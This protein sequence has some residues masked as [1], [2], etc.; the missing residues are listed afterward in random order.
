MSSFGYENRDG[1]ST[2]LRSIRASIDES[3]TGLEPVNWN[4]VNGLLQQL[5]F[6]PS[7]YKARCSLEDDPLGRLLIGRILSRNPPLATL[8]AALAVFPESLD[9]NASAFFTACRDGTTDLLAH[10]MH[11]TTTKKNEGENQK[12]ENECPYPWILSSHISVEGAQAILEVFPQGV[13]QKSSMFSMYNLVDYFLMSK[14]MIEQ[15]NFDFTLWSKF[16]LILVAAE[17]CESGRE[18][19]EIY[20]V[21][22]ILKR[23]L[24]H[25]GFLENKEWTQHV[26]WLL[27]QLRWSDQWVFEKQT[28]DGKNPIHLVLSHQCT[29]KQEG[30]VAA[31]ELAK[32]L[33]EA[34]PQSAKRWVDG[35]LPLHMAVKNGWPCHD[36]LL[37]LFPEALD[38][39]DMQTELFPFQAAAKYHLTPLSLDIAY[40]LLRANPSCA[41][42]MTEGRRVRAQG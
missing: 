8:D 4:I 12:L 34:H 13:L 39:R 36:L 33:L 2:L 19:G 38:A 15:R 16:K 25:P 40:E 28:S 21:H 17:S 30:L 20:P 1:P 14:D 18:H 11:H 32:I 31:R 5:H 6:V 23:V 10:M 7:S 29:S 24:S 27:H 41:R 35:Q 9:R 3:L 37:S 26:L 42:N 22:T